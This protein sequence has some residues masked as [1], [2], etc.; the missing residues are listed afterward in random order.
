[1]IPL[2]RCWHLYNRDA[3]EFVSCGKSM[4][5]TVFLKTFMLY[6]M[7][8]KSV[9]T[10]L[11]LA[12]W[13]CTKATF[14]CIRKIGQEISGLDFRTIT[15]RSGNMDKIMDQL[16]QVAIYLRL[17]KDDGDFSSA[18]EGKAESNSIHNQRELLLSFLEKHPEMELYD[19]YK[20]DGRTGTNFD[21]P[22]FKRM[23]K[24]IRTG[25]VNCIIVKDLSRFGRDYIECG[26]YIEKIFPQLGVRFISVN[27]GFDTA[28]AGS[29]DSIVIPFKN[30]INDSY[31]RDISIKVRSNLDVKRRQGE[32]ISNFAVYGYAKDPKDKNHLIIDGYAAEV[33]R[34]IFKW[35]LEGLSPDRI[36]DRLN[37]QGILSPMEYKRARGSRFKS[38]FKTG[39]RASWSH[40]AVRRILQ[41]EVY[42]GA[43]IQG[44]RT[45]PNHKVKRLVYKDESEWVRVEGR[46]EAIIEKSQFDLVQQVLS[47]D[48][49]AAARTV[50]VH[51]YCGRI[52]CAD[53]GASMV[54]KTAN[55][56]GKR[57]VYYVCSANKSNKAIC[58][59]HSIREDILDTAVLETI[60]RQIEIALDL[61]SV[62]QQI[63]AF[64]WEKTELK[65]IDRNV[66]YQKQV[67]EKNNTLRLSIYED[68]REGILSKDEFLT[69]K[70]E[71]SSR[72][73][74]AKGAIEQMLMDKNSIMDGLSRQQSWLSRFREYENVSEISRILIVNLV[75]RINIFENSEIEVVFRH[76][77][78]FAGIMEFLE[79]QKKK[80]TYE[81]PVACPGLEVV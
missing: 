50:S 68:L 28:S 43:L 41:N 45:T 47:E 51:P 46:H 10:L 60:Q 25:V 44:K 9:N 22:D 24:D 80:E 74:E 52:Y 39:S 14:G 35:K 32:F 40:V 26:K 34:D 76:Q 49:R 58:S 56:G 11:L 70:A 78:Q 71:F 21:R 38:A 8:T 20:D 64:D 54:R 27:D 73:E 6:C 53:C 77:D 33:V 79:T 30:L 3:M 65:K 4:E 59:R 48:T 69:L 15:D 63:D 12:C 66:E 37:Q 72:I 55:S 36:A 31:S 2:V 1:M 67:I 13:Q 57:Y 81:E 29:S 42:T 75:S 62:M 19:E 18:E 7:W 16:F 17:S 5:N 61:D 23:M